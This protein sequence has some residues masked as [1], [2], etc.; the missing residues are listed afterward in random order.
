MVW[1][2]RKAKSFAFIGWLMSPLY[3]FIY[4]GSWGSALSLSF[5]LKWYFTQSV[6]FSPVSINVSWKLA[7]KMTEFF[8]SLK[9]V[10]T[11]HLD[12]HLYAHYDPNIFWEI[13]INARW[14]VAIQKTPHQDEWRTTEKTFQIERLI[15]R[16]HDSRQD[17]LFH[18]LFGGCTCAS[19][20][21]SCP[22]RCSDR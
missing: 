2:V 12:V 20:K 18:F 8:S 11:S 6:L 7:V 22:E 19:H 14:I 3:C 5:I 17:I 10:Q 21:L 9:S 1:D 16:V 15:T 4:F 13:Q